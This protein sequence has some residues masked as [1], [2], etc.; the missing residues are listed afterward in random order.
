MKEMVEVVEL[1]TWLL[2]I[3]AIMIILTVIPMIGVMWSAFLDIDIQ[4]I[5]ERIKGKS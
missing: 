5:I 3:I 4:D 2:I 1:P